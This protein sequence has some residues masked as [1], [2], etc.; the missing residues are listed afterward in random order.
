M[1]NQNNPWR[2]EDVM[3]MQFIVFSDIH[4]SLLPRDPVISPCS[5]RTFIDPCCRGV[6]S[7]VLA[8]AGHSSI[9]AAAGSSQQSLLW[10]DIHRSLLPRDP[11]NIPCSGR[12]SIDP[13]C[14][15][16]KSSVL[17]LA[18][19]PSILA[20]AGSSHQS[21]LWQDI[22][23]PLLPRDPVNIPCSGRTSIDPC[24][25]GIKSSVLAL[26]GHPSILAA[27]GSSHQSLLWQD[28]HRPLLP[29]GP[30]NIPC[31]GRTSID[32]SC[33]G[34]KSSVLAL[35]G[36]PSVLAAAGSSH[37]SLLWQGIHRSLLPRDPVIS[38][39]SG[40][41]SIGPCCRGIHGIKSSVLALAGHP[42]ILAAA[43]S[44]HQ[45]LLWQDI[46]R[47]LLPR[48]PVNIPCSG[49]T[50]IDPCCRGIKSSVLALAGHP[51]ILAAAGSSHQSL[52][53]QDIHRS[54]LPRDPVNIPCS[55]RTSIDPSCS[56]I[57]S[58]VL[59]LAGHPS[60][61][62]AAG[63]S[64]QSLLWQDIHQSLLPRDPV[65]SPCSG[66]TFSDPC[67][68]GVKS[69]VLALAGHP[70]VLAAAG[71]SQQSLLW[72]DI[73][74]SLLLRDLVISPCSGRTSNNPCC[75]GIQSSVLALAGHPSILAA[76]GSSQQSLL[77]QDSH[78][79]LSPQDQNR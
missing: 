30:V 44:S 8:L 67:C 29:R 69:S 74:Q 42:S 27:A 56:G 17:A 60:I 54:L 18:G 43:G 35:A 28:I 65:I 12:T 6:Q 5:G 13:S 77:W 4:R 36:H 25:R 21:L 41:T 22:H 75:C 68:R 66:R 40:R 62:A 53:W 37:Q 76:A 47:P 52:L 57:K 58:S 48:D 46:H 55:G 78:Q 11:V 49:R 63:S 64:H 72:Q 23:R 32:P 14:S 39:C 33:R 2:A 45:S 70:S 79:S 31:S 16:I 61:L 50:S 59:A 38:P 51:S 7:S 24:C 1:N 20:A 26:A 71:S 10:Q 9:L 73:Q 34:I 15:G 19:H 3:P